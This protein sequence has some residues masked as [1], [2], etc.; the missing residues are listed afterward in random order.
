MIKRLLPPT[1]LACAAVTL[2]A[3]P[4]DDTTIG[5][6][7][8]PFVDEYEEVLRGPADAIDLLSIGDSLTSDNFAN[9]GDITVEYVDGSE[10]VVHMQRFTVQKTQ[11]AA[12]DAFSRMQFWG[13]DQSTPSKPTEDMAAIA[14]FAEDTSNCYARAYYDGLSQP[15][16]DGVN[17]RVEIP[18]GWEGDLVL[19]TEDN[20]AEG[21]ESYPSRGDVSVMGLAGNL[22]VELDS[23]NVDVKLDPNAR[24]FPGCGQPDDECYAD[25]ATCNCSEPMNIAVGNRTSQSSNIT[26]DIADPALPANPDFQKWWTVQLENRGDFSS[27]SEF[28]CNATV[29][30]APFTSCEINPDFDDQDWQERAEIN[31]PGEDVGAIKGAGIR[32]AVYS[33]EC[34]IV[35]YVNGPDDFESEDLPE[36]KRGELNFCV[37]CL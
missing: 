26:I 30:C 31:F 28:V 22:E 9:R 33:E 6:G 27:G 24:H 23:G 16:R 34:T 8:Q 5:E 32:V 15:A 20:L 10:I 14:C 25:W 12:D 4:S 13:Y 7:R 18:K 11:A 21:I 3:C 2:T 36:E 17:F 1:L 29:D 35:S 37:G 19:I